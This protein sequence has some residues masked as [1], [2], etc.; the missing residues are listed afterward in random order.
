MGVG[1]GGLRGVGDGPTKTVESYVGEGDM[2]A[3][4][5][6]TPSCIQPGLHRQGRV[7]RVRW[8]TAL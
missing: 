7:I 1:V 5:T 3:T 4:W 6:R 2:R 8:G